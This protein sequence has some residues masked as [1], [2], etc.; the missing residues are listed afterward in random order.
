MPQELLNLFEI[1]EI[2]L[3]AQKMKISSIDIQIITPPHLK[4]FHRLIIKSTKKITPQCAVRLLQKNSNF[5]ISNF[6][7]K[8]KLEDLGKPPHLNTIKCG[9]KNWIENLKESLRI[10][11]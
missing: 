3:L 11:V 7:I 2:K 10:L 9:G 4:K 6:E 8:I 1:L 5:N